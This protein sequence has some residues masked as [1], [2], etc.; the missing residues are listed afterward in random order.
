VLLIRFPLER[1]LLW[2]MAPATVPGLSKVLETEQVGLDCWSNS[3]CHPALNWVWPAGRLWLT[4]VGRM[5]APLP[6]SVAHASTK[7][8][9]QRQNGHL[10]A[11]VASAR[12]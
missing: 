5:V 9:L 10:L 6:S 7:A 3:E 11:M 12:A 8:T 1:D 2:Q 4:V